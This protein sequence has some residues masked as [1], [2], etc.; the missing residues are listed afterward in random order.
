MPQQSR[1]ALISSQM[2]LSSLLQWRLQSKGYQVMLWRRPRL[3]WGRFTL[4]RLIDHSGFFLTL[5][6]LS[7]YALHGAQ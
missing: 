5:C 4:I 3:P 6:R 1:I 7:R 2:Q